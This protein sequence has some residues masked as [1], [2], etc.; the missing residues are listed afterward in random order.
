MVLSSS[1]IIPKQRFTILKK[2]YVVITLSLPG[3]HALYNELKDISC[4]GTN[5]EDGKVLIYYYRSKVVRCSNES[6]VFT[7]LML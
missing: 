1:Q 5:L 6:R 2:S 3:C 7:Y 4:Y